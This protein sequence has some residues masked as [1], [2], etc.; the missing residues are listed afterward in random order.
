[1][2]RHNPISPEDIVVI[3][4]VAH[5]QDRTL[6]L[7]LGMAQVEPL[8][9]IIDTN[10]AEMRLYGPLVRFDGKAA[11]GS[12]AFSSYYLNEH[13][14][15]MIAIFARVEMVC[16]GER[17]AAVHRGIRE[18]FERWGWAATAFRRRVTTPLSE[19]ETQG[20]A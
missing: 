9:A 8:Q 18:E 14:A 19:T 15:Q 16:S 11:D 17:S 12:H 2:T 6:A 1:M 4:G 13:Q 7:R 3:Y 10:A 20:A 5:L